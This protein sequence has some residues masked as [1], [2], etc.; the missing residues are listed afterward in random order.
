MRLICPNC[1]AQYEVPD[2]VIPA[3]GRDVQ[4]SN[5]SHTWFE[6]PGM[7]EAEEDGLTPPP[8]PEGEYPVEPQPAPTPIDQDDAPAAEMEQGEEEPEPE[9][10]PEEKPEVSGPEPAPAPEPQRRELDPAIADILRQEAARER[11]QRD[12]SASDGLQSQPD[13]GLDAP[14]APEDQR[15]EEAR[16]RMA[17]LKGERAP[18][19]AVAG[20]GARSDL[21]P[22]IEEI[23]STLRSSAERG[24]SDPVEDAAISQNRRSGFRRGFMTVILLAVLAAVIYIYAP[25]IGAAVP[26]LEPV[27]TSYVNWVDSLRLWIDLKMQDFI[28]SDAA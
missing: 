24:E 25:R 2:D 27:L 19:P 7:S 1:G 9:Y 28:A 14:L 15:A 21:L 12:G 22:D 20:V 18:A 11:A 6:R 13:L 26:Q 16:R 5:C 10:E 3:A 8:P 4:C 23:N 17:R